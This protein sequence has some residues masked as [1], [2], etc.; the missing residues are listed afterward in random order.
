MIKS[1]MHKIILL[2]LYVLVFMLCCLSIL[3]AANGEEQLKNLASADSGAIFI[4]EPTST[5][6]GSLSYIN[7][8][9]NSSYWYAGDG[10]P[11]SAVLVRLREPGMIHS[12]RFL[13]W[14]TGRHAPGDYQVRAIN[15]IS[16]ESHLIADVKGDTTLGPNWVEL[17]LDSPVLADQILI[18]IDDVQEHEHGALLY[19]VQVLGTV[20]KNSDDSVKLE[21][22]KVYLLADIGKSLSS[23]SSDNITMMVSAGLPGKE[24]VIFTESL[25]SAGFHRK[26]IDLSKWEGKTI[27]L[28]FEASGNTQDAGVWLDPHIVKGDNLIANLIDYWSILHEGIAEG[29]VAGNNNSRTILCPLTSGKSR[30]TIKVPLSADVIRDKLNEHAE[31]ERR[32]YGASEERLQSRG[33][34]SQELDLTGKWQMASHDAVETTPIGTG[35]PRTLPDM[36]GWQWH[37]VSIPGSIRSGLTEAGVI[38]DPYWSDNAGKSIWTEKE[39]WWFKKTVIVPDNW[40]GR[41]IFLGF[42]GIDYYSSVWVNGVFL[43]DHEGMYGGP[44]YDLAP[45]IR[46]GKPN[47]V[48]V[49][50]HPGGTDEPGKVYKGFIF[51]KWHYQTDISPRGIWQGVRLISTDSIRIENLYVKTLT[52]DD[53]DALLEISGSIYNYGDAGQA[54]IEGT[55]KGA[56]FKS[57]DKPVSIPVNLARGEQTFTCQYRIPNPRLWWPHG[58]G[59]P[60]LYRLELGARI[61]RKISDTVSTTF[62]IRTIEFE[63][64]PGLDSDVNSR[65]MC[66][67]NGKLI[68]MRGA[69]GFGAHDQIYRYH[70]RKDAWFIKTA[71]D[72]NFNFIRIHGSGII[73]SD[74]FYDLCDRM[75]MM[76]WQEF[77]I[78]NMGISGEHPDVWRTQTIQSILRLRSHPSLIRWCGGNEFNPDSTSDDTKMIVD[79][80][81]D[82]VKKFDGM[83]L[84]S[85]AA[86]YVNDPHYNDESGLYGGF[87]PA[88]CTEYGGAFAGSIIGERSL[89]KFLPEKDVTLWPPTTKEK[90]DHVFT[91]D[92]WS[93]IDN[94]NRGPFVFHTALTGRCEGW[95]WPGDLTVVLPYW[96][97]MGNPRTMDDAYEISQVYGGYTTAYTMETLRSRWPY[98]SLYASWDFAPIWPMSIIWGPVDYYGKVLPCAYYYKRAQE[99]LHILMQYE[100]EELVKTPVVP[101]NAFPKIYKPGE[102]FKGRIF[103]ASDLNHPMKDMSADI[104]VFNS[105]LALIHRAEIKADEVKSGPSSHLLGTFTL[106]ISP[107]M[108]NQILLICISLKDNNGKL[109]SRSA[110]PIW[111]S[112][113]RTKLISDVS[114]RR[115]NGPWLTDI[116]NATTGLRIRAISKT[117]EFSK[118]DYLPAGGES[119]GNAILEV[120]NIGDKPAFHTG[121]E[122]TNADC[123]Y[124]CDDNYFLLMPGETKQIKIEIDRSVQPF[125]EGVKSELIQPIGNELEF[126][127]KA[128]NSSAKTIRIPV[129]DK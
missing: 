3:S 103:I 41:Q 67:V 23:P 14:S 7:D 124:V 68:S 13:S 112:S 47:E 55:I 37:S 92:V 98:P 60:D 36:N 58:M 38:E 61:H 75:G 119:L 59:N 35:K 54:L 104:Q 39:N 114:A 84:F 106:E 29:A 50:I 52:I 33:H 102:Q 97:F 8:G 123:R 10:Q 45:V 113:E 117:I 56:N 118:K 26:I 110:Y 18:R 48:V 128:W 15:S 108:P 73:A 30:I 5:G 93:R 31:L 28:S 85:R 122:I 19:E 101:L 46:F 83:R 34:G 100:P 51:M 79:M 53:K 69:G 22:D 57:I 80:F 11:K 96:L 105:G 1:D 94:S 76:V 4:A 91:P 25:T 71:Q 77:M 12:V 64:N 125:Y 86:Q 121:V 43:G 70:A 127:I 27:N 107:Q 126:T 88:A 32:K 109:L 6:N 72:L 95:G 111:I 17:K 90:L 129:T 87:K 2:R 74:K 20:V 66:R 115:D 62:G 82:C 21:P 49:Q 78:S 40:S 116:K 9:Y 89:N 63:Q 65:F 120:T 81:E 44:V 16:G 24:S 99:P 42:D